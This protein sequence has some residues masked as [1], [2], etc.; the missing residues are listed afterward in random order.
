MEKIGFALP[1]M[2]GDHHVMEV[3]RILA[4]IPGVDHIYASSGFQMVEMEYDPDQVS[5][6]DIRSA[7]RTAGY[8]EGEL[9]PVE[10]HRDPTDRT[11]P[12]P[13]FRHTTAFPNIQKT[14]GFKQEVAFA[15]SPLWPCPGIPAAP[16]EEEVDHG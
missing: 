3:R 12:E 8:L 16:V 6:E 15:G 5:P 10:V 4:A 11:G 9:A 14:I 2:F 13:Y 7:L 1:S